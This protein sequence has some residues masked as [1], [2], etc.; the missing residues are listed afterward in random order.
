MDNQEGRDRI[1]ALIETLRSITLAVQVIPF[2]YTGLYIIVLCTYA[3]AP[4]RVLE[5]LDTLFY[6]SPTVVVAFLLESRILKLCHWHRA[7]C[8]LPLLPQVSVFVDSYIYELAER[9][10]YALYLV[11]IAMSVLLLVAA[12]KVFLSP[13]QD[14]RERRTNRDS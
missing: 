5:A 10:V 9:G 13:K 7:A 11:I 2:V 6:V 14:G 4:E 8:A 3:F 1:L 12:Y